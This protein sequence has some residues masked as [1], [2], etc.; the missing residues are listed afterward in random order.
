M[1]QQGKMGIDR[2]ASAFVSKVCRCVVSAPRS[3]QNMS[4]LCILS[5]VLPVLFGSNMRGYFHAN[6]LV[7]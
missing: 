6:S 2:T 7:A 5:L 1:R 4:S 3:I